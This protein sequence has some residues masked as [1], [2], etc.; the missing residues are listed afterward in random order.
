MYAYVRRLFSLTLQHGVTQEHITFHNCI[1]YQLVY[2][3]K[4]ID[5]RLAEKYL[6]V[7]KLH[8]E[9]YPFCKTPTIA[10]DPDHES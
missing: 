3:K 6:I 7:F 8:C 10:T 5:T 2:I 1:A 9:Q 4:C